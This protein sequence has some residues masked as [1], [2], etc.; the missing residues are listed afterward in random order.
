MAQ[1]PNPPTQERGYSDFERVRLANGALHE[2]GERQA[3]L[4]HAAARLPRRPWA[5]GIDDGR[6]EVLFLYVGV[7][8]LVSSFMVKP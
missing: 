8:K 1:V 3:L 4:A 6:E 7:R 5:Y 2:S